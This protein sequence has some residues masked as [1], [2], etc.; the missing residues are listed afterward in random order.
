MEHLVCSRIAKIDCRIIGEIRRHH[1]TIG[2]NAAIAIAVDIHVM[3]HGIASCIGLLSGSR[4][5]A[6]D[7][8]GSSMLHRI[9]QFRATCIEHSSRH[10]ICIQIQVI[11]IDSADRQR[12]CLPFP[13]SKVDLRIRRQAVID[14]SSQRT[15]R[16]DPAA[17]PVSLDRRDAIAAAT[18]RHSI[19]RVAVTGPACRDMRDQLIVCHSLI[20]STGKQTANR[21]P[22]GISRQGRAVLPT[23]DQVIDLIAALGNIDLNRCLIGCLSQIRLEAAIEGR[24]IPFCRR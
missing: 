15:D 18:D 12:T 21:D 20:G 10:R 22:V 16:D 1:R 24:S 23:D 19:Q 6:A 9:L 8:H 13:A 11:V 17:I 14:D 5:R 4:Y 2:R 3:V 7:I